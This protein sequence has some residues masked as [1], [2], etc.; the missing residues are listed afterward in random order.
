MVREEVKIDFDSEKGFPL[1]QNIQNK[2]NF[3]ELI[4]TNKLTLILALV[5]LIMLGLGVF[6]YRD[7]YLDSSDKV[8]VISEAEE[9]QVNKKELVVEIA[10]A[11]EKPGVYRLPREARIED[12]LIVAGGI[13][14][15]ADRIW[16]EKMVN[17]AAK[18]VDG[19]KVYIP[20]VSEQSSVLSDKSSS[21]GIS[22]LSD[23]IADTTHLINI[24][25][26]SSSEL[27][28][29]NGI[30]PVYAKSVIEHRPYSSKEEL[31]TKNALKKNVYEKIKDK[32]TVY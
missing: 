29:L 18:L 30:G 31:L 14:S 7:G 12:L 20:A 28:S 25:S 23:N 5:G 3:E 19:Q 10:G 17:R 9:D 13:S 21:G 15:E 32:I 16:M 1:N 6:L 22:G 26:A 27:E 11:V 24:N 8:E 4:E 2:F